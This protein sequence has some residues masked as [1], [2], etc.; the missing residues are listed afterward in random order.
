MCVKPQLLLRMLDHSAYSLAIQKQ[1][2][3]S[4]SLDESSVLH[5]VELY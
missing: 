2:E 1:P 3:P 5:V 4:R